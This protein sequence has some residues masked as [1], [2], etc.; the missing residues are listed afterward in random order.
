MDEPIRRILDEHAH[1]QVDVATL[2]DDSD[3][4]QAGLTSHSSVSL[5]LALEDEFDVEFPQEMLRK[6]TFESI[7]AIRGAL[8]QLGAVV[9]R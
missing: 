6:K 3:L 8:A 4:Y 5:M 9:A 1:L 2:G 7:S